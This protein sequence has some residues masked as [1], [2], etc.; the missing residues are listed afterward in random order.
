MSNQTALDLLLQEANECLTAG[1]HAVPVWTIPGFYQDAAGHTAAKRLMEED[2]KT[3]YT[4]ALAYRLTGTAAYAV[5]AKEILLGWASANQEIAGPDG[6]L[7]SAYLGVGLIRAAEWLRGYSGWG[8]N[9]Q[10]SFIAWMTGTALPAW[11]R[12]PLRNNWWSWSLYAQLALFRLTNDTARFAEEVTAFKEQLD[13]SLSPE[14]F[15]PE[16]TQRGKHSVWYHYFALA[17]LTAATKLI[18]DT[19]GE[20]LFN[21]TTPG[22]KSLRTA[23]DRFFYYVD[24]RLA[25]W[26]Y[27]GAPLFPAP[28]CGH[29]W[30]LDLF[31]AMSKVY[32]NPDY[33][34]FVSP[35]RPIRGSLNTNS[36]FYH[37]YAWIYPE[38]LDNGSDLPLWHLAG[39][40]SGE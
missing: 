37:S 12:I 9:E 22:G 17:P 2:A 32:R 3:A 30:P 23:L 24:G 36:G 39:G 25:E 6:P 21:W 4:T 10:E 27:D 5:K 34:R 26:P 29:T 14:G 13:S 18:Q 1:C 16:E 38:L 33:D 20:D 28:L 40:P 11:D 31:E 7:V 19:T 35:Y 8:R 15:I